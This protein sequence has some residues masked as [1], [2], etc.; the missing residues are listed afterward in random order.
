MLPRVK[1]GLLVGGIGL[2][3][4]T[5]VAVVLG[6][7]GPFVALLAG[8]LAGFM[9][10]QQEKPLLKGD[11]ARLGAVAGG[12]AGTLVCIG[13]VI[14]GLG[15]LV[16][17]QYAGLTPLF[18]RLPSA[19]AGPGEQLVYYVAG[20][21]TGLCFG[22]VGLVLAALAGAGGGYLGSPGLA[23]DGPAFPSA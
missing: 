18:G 17:V 13:Q 7:C 1:V 23:K 19:S 12:I 9:A 22:L 10:A 3:L 11:G 4:N 20:L 15:A 16:L 21:G 6:L 14:G 5:C 8:A 2:L